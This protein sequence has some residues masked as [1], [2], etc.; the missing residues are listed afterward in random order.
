MLGNVAQGLGLERI[1]WD[2]LNNGKYTRDLE[3]GMSGISIGQVLLKRYQK[4]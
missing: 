3:L 4:N 1:L 2:D